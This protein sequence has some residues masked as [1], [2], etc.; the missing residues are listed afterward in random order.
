MSDNTTKQSR[1]LRLTHHQQNIESDNAMTEQHQFLFIL[2]FN[3]ISVHSY[4][5][6]LLIYY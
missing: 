5:I 3:Y 2:T 1:H 4:V 6:I